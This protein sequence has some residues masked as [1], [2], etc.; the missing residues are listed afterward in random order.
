MITVNQNHF[1]YEFQ[2]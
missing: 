2:L 1:N